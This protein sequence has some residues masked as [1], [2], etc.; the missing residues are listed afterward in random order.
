MT[1]K[2]KRSAVFTPQRGTFS[3][4]FISYYASAPFKFIVDGEPLYIHTDLVSLHSKPLDRLMN[5]YM[6]EAE[7][8]FATLPDVDGATFVRFIEWA[9]KGYYTAAEFSTDV[10]EDRC[11]ENDQASGNG[12]AHIAEPL[13]EETAV[14]DNEFGWGKR[15]KNKSKGNFGFSDPDPDPPVFTTAR[16]DLRNS[17]RKPIKSK[18]AI[19]APPPRQNE[20]RTENYSEVFLSHARLYVFAEMYDIQPLKSRALNEL[21]ATLAIFTLYPQRT[22]D[23]ITLLRYVYTNTSKPKEGVE[24][25]RT[26]MTHYMGFEMDVLMDDPSFG[27]LMIEDPELEN[28]RDFLGDYMTMVQKR[29]SSRM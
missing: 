24:D 15:K 1:A 3:N 28:R 27:D 19:K 12:G 11:T 23:I 25:L 10:E 7:K 18:G 8:G 9:H 6:A 13:P 2:S 5:G 22:G 29:I 16:E 26:L 20:S 14:I 4:E 21:H 17:F